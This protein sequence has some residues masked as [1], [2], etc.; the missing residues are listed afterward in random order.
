MGFA[1]TWTALCPPAKLYP[2]VMAAL[3]LFNFYR[4]TYRHAIVNAV[5]A[6]VG[7]T[8]LAVLCASGFEFAAWALLL[9]PVLFFVFLLAIIFYD[10]TLFDITRSYDPNRLGPGG[11]RKPVEPACEPSCE[12]EPKC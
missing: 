5:Y 1:E 10:Q 2:I 7:T 11:C 3:I 4:G 12:P 6:L 8:L 9:L